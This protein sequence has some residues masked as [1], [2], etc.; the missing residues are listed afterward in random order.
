MQGVGCRVR[1]S[2]RGLECHQLG[3]TPKL[4]DDSSVFGVRGFRVQ[5]FGIALGSG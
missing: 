4:Q 3:L 1:G 2:V 5:V